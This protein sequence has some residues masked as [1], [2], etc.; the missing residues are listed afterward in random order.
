[1]PGPLSQPL[2]WRGSRGL[3]VRLLVRSVAHWRASTPD[4]G[5]CSNGHE[6]GQSAG[7]GRGGDT[8][9]LA[10]DAEDLLEI[11]FPSTDRHPK[12]VF[13]RS[14][15]ARPRLIVGA[16]GAVGVVEVD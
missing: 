7:R 2:P 4:G 12:P 16:V 10:Q 1:M 15:W 3:F 8:P 6:E 5:E 11:H 9:A 14:D 13:A